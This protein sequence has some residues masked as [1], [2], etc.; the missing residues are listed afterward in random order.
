MKK[1]IKSDLEIVNFTIHPAKSGTRKG[2]KVEIFSGLNK[3]SIEAAIARIDKNAT[4]KNSSFGRPLYCTTIKCITPE[5]SPEENSNTEE[6]QQVK[7]N[8]RRK[9]YLDS[10]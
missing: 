5:K 4:G 7:T 8:T 9:K 6:E 1:E 3:E 2:T 10:Y